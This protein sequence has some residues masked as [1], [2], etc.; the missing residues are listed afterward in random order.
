MARHPP[1]TLARGRENIGGEEV[2]MT[3]TG[4]RMATRP[5]DSGRWM[6]TRPGGGVRRAVAAAAAAAACAAIMA[7]A[8]C[9]AGVTAAPALTVASAYVPIPT[10]TE[11]G[12]TVAFLDIRN[13]GAADQLVA[14]STSVGGA[15]VFRAPAGQDTTVMKTVPAIAI[16]AA[17]TVRLRPNSAHLL[18][19][20]AGRMRGG[21]DITIF[22]TF[23]RAGRMPVIAQ[24]SDPESG[25]GGYFSN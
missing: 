19:T 20:G 4:R 7:S 9:A 22:L 13:N 11:P 3:T 8:G 1:G 16:P 5:G 23:V 17:T 6:A 25:V 10:N 24:V 18:I 21:K 15:V 14:A 12:T 2:T